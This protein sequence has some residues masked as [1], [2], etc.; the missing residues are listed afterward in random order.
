MA[1][2]SAGHLSDEGTHKCLHAIPPH[3]RCKLHIPF[4]TQG[5]LDNERHEDERRTALEAIEKLLQSK[6][7]TFI[8]DPSGLQAKRAYTIQ[9]HLALIVK[10]GQKVKESLQDN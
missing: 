6:K 10:N 9:S 8:S 3:K 1:I 4:H 2:D 7:T 5:K